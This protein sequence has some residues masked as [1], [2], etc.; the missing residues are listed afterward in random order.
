MKAT[1]GGYKSE[2]V[3]IEGPTSDKNE[4][5]SS[6][7]LSEQFVVREELLNRTY[8]FLGQINTTIH[9]QIQGL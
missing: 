8:K 9:Q 6:A 1:D 5:K 7:S 2:P 4:R 3:S